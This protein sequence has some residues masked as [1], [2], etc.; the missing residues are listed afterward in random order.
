M[1]TYLLA[2]AVT[3][4]ASRQNTNEANGFVQHIYAR[5]NAIH[6]SAFG[7]ETG[8]RIMDAFE[9]HFG[10]KYS[11]PK[12][13]QIALPGF[14]GGAMENWGLIIYGWVER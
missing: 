12:M 2:F 13:D 8:R 6:K 11:L 5:P 3:D 10:V 14:E 9:G 1:P 4:Y 7:L